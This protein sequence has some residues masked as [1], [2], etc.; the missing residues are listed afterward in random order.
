MEE[1]LARFVSDLDI[2]VALHFP[3][4]HVDRNL[5]IVEGAQA[6]LEVGEQRVNLTLSK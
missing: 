1:M 2:P 5:P 4:G 3:I 6:T